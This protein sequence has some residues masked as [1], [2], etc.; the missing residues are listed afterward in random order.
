MAVFK[1]PVRRQKKGMRQV[2]LIGETESNSKKGTNVL[3]DSIKLM[4]IATF[5][6]N[7][8]LYHVVTDF[9]KTYISKIENNNFVTVDT[10]SNS[11]IWTYE[12]V[13]IR[14]IDGHYIVFFKTQ[15]YLEIY[16][17]KINLIRYN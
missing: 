13:V 5:P 15:G 6:F 7:D 3:V 9:K 2:Y 14:T 10:I 8:Q 12:P 4:T 11:S 17:N 16:D 1:L